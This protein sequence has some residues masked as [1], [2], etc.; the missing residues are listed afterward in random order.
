MPELRRQTGGSLGLSGQSNIELM[1]SVRDD[2]SKGRA[3]M[4]KAMRKRIILQCAS[5]FSIFHITKG[6][7]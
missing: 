1:R 3:K 2:R 6:L 5:S 7:Q 4:L